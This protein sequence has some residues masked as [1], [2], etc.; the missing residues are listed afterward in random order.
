MKKKMSNSKSE[1]KL[2]EEVKYIVL[3]SLMLGA[4]SGGTMTLV[5]AHVG[6]EFFSW[7][8]TLCWL[9]I[10]VLC[11]MKLKGLRNRE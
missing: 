1:K 5:F 11:K 10:F 7:L 4:A 8:L 9:I 6:A 2:D 3:E